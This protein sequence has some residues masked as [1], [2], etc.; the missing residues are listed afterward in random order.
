LSV[1]HQDL[2]PSGAG[3]ETNGWPTVTLVSLRPPVAQ[4]I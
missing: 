4:G 2:L 3:S 1:D